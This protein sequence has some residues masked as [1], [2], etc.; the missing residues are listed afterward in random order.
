VNQAMLLIS[1]A[2]RADAAARLDRR[3]RAGRSGEL[4]GG[5]MRVASP[6]TV[7]LVDLVKYGLAL[8]G[9]AANWLAALRRRR[10]C[11]GAHRGHP[12]RFAL[13]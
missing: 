8:I 12:R 5:Q 3:A 11:G 1:T 7:V 4:S 13:L 9:R 10:R 2:G 6:P